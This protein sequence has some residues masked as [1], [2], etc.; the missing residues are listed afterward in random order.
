GW[1]CVEYFEDN[2]KL[3]PSELPP[4]LGKRIRAY[5][6][7]GDRLLFED[8]ACVWPSY[9]FEGKGT[10]H[11][12]WAECGYLTSGWNPHT[13][14]GEKGQRNGRFLQGNADVL[15]VNGRLDWE[16]LQWR[17]GR[18]LEVKCS[19]DAHLAA[20]SFRATGYPLPPLPPCRKDR[21]LLKMAYRTLQCCTHDTFMDCPFYERMMYIG[22][23][24]VEA[25]CLYALGGNPAIA[26]KA[27]RLTAL[28]QLPDGMI[29]SRYPARVFQYI[30]SFVPIWIL[31]LDDYA[32]AT[33]DLGF[34][35]EMLPVARRIVSL[36]Q[37]SRKDDALVH[38]D[39]WQFVDWQWPNHGIPF[40]SECGTNSIINLLVCLALDRLSR[41]EERC[42]HAAV[43][44]GLRDFQKRLL[45]AVQERYFVPYTGLYSD[46]QEHLFFSEHAQVLALLMED[47]QSLKDGL[48][49]HPFQTSCGINFSHYYLEACRLHGL[50]RLFE[51][52]LDRYRELA[53]L[54]LKTL[55]EE[56]TLPRSDCHA[57]S[58]HVL[59]HLL[60]REGAAA[61]PR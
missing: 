5:R 13:L 54:G 56:F 52:R 60:R 61:S 8:Y 47:R 42:G 45:A 17:A 49:T 30:P 25:L 32:Q 19:G 34:V 44:L 21:G 14:K 31:M 39:G 27:I 12:R 2:R 50:R 57:W 29:P 51:R 28:H 6:R 59:Y 1:R 37:N 24:R 10:V 20:V 26:R 40:G 33:Q 58:A 46:D 53:L 23:C 3:V 16:D 35:E 43:A 22:D 41:L 18:I 48:A 15:H 9:R 36:F 38:L 4:L 7:E 55:P 11:I